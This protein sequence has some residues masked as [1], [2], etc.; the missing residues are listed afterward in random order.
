MATGTDIINFGATPVDEA[1]KLVTSGVSGLTSAS[2]IEAWFMKET[3]TDNGVEE[4]EEAAAV[5][6]LTCQ[7]VNAT[8][9]FVLAMPIAALGTG[10]FTFRWATL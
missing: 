2:Y 1:T 7:F 3:S 5:C 9:F 6:P 8:S 4:H 10:Q